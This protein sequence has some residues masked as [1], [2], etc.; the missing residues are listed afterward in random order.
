MNFRKGAQNHDVPAFANVFERVRRIIEELEI[1][2][3]ENNNDIFREARHELVDLALRNQ[4]TGGIIGICDENH[5]R[6]WRDRIQDRFK[7]L[8]IIRTSRFNRASAEKGRDQFIGDKGVF[9]RD[10]VIPA[11][12]EG[13]PEEFD[14]LI[15]SVTQNDVLRGETEPCGKRL[16]QIK[17][18]AIGIKL[19][20]FQRGAHRGNSL[21]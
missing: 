5:A 15:R 18:S 12:E 11:M 20:V 10:Y 8:L 6:L 13:M 7:I 3:V 9:G 21:W 1:R 17:T 19:R 16:A 2:F 14:H 4:S